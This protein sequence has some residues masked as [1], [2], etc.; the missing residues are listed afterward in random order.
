M[1]PDVPLRSGVWERFENSP[2]GPHTRRN[3]PVKRAK[4]PRTSSQRTR[5]TCRFALLYLLDAEGCQATLAGCSGLRAGT[6]AS[7]AIIELDGSDA[8][9]PLRQVGRTGRTVE[10]REAIQRLGPLPGGPWP[11]PAQQAVILPLARPAHA[12]VAGFLVAGV[13]PHGH[14]TTTHPRFPQAAGRAGRCC[15]RRHPGLRGGAGPWP[16]RRPRCTGGGPILVACRPGVPGAIDA[17]PGVP[18]CGGGP[19]VSGIGCTYRT[20]L[21]RDGRRVAGGRLGPHRCA[22]PPD[23]FQPGSRRALRAH[24]GAW[25]RSVVHRL[26]AVPAG[27][28]AAWHE[29]PWPWRVREGRV[30]RDQE[31][32][33]ERPDGTR[34]WIMP[35]P[36]PLR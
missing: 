7:P 12:Q 6:P 3:R 29:S 21:P 9:W 20:S 11:E 10:G 2:P 14:S 23:A 17:D 26:G 30:A 13:S 4:R 22:R 1:I 35:C 24:A 34:V 16:Q 33:A 36:T 18:G 27:R 15:S 32:I 19:N 5:G 31:I 8:P 25:K 28:H